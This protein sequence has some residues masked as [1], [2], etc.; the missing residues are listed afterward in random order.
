MIF[1]CNI[2][3][4]AYY[5]EKCNGMVYIILKEGRKRKIASKGRGFLTNNIRRIKLWNFFLELYNVLVS[6]VT[7]TL[8]NKFSTKYQLMTK[9]VFNRWNSLLSSIQ[10]FEKLI[11]SKKTLIFQY[12]QRI[13]G[14]KKLCNR[15]NYLNTCDKNFFYFNLI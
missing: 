4:I 10:F 1:F 11:I 7:W 6:S 3:I 5:G 12:L 9:K 8:W 14:I 2:F 13:F 15:W